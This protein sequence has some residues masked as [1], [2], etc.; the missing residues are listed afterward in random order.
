MGGEGLANGSVASQFAEKAA[1]RL[2]PVLTH[3]FPCT[4]DQS[5]PLLLTTLCPTWGQ[6]APLLELSFPLSPSATLNNPLLGTEK[7]ELNLP[8][9]HVDICCPIAPHMW[10][11]AYT[12]AMLGAVIHDLLLLVFEHV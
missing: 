6:G 3:G 5:Q 7:K 4:R 11:V 1:T 8:T 2:V 10:E 9:W 12:P